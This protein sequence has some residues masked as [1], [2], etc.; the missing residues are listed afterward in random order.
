MG[1]RRRGPAPVLPASPRQVLPH[2]TGPAPPGLAPAQEPGGHPEA[3]APGVG[4]GASQGG[5]TTRVRRTRL[6]KRRTRSV[7][8]HDHKS[9]VSIDSLTMHPER[10]QALSTRGVQIYQ[11][12]LLWGST[13]KWEKGSY[14]PWIAAN[15]IRKGGG[16]INYGAEYTLAKFISILYAWIENFTLATLTHTHTH[17]HT[18]TRT[19]SRVRMKTGRPYWMKAVKPRSRL[20]TLLSLFQYRFTGIQ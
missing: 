9:I 10:C 5:G 13:G 8:R 3:R 11:I 20:S 2:P 6:D 19:I 4:W 17:T 18:H 1:P 14:L 12:P 7:S 16:S 15:E